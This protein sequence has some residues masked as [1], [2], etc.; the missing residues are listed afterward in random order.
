MLT[1]LPAS[2]YL[3]QQFNQTHCDRIIHLLFDITEYLMHFHEQ[4][5]LLP[6]SKQQT[7]KKILIIDDDK[8]VL[9]MLT[10]LI[11][12]AGYATLS[13]RDGEEG[14]KLFH[15]ENPDL[16]VTDLIMPNKEGL[17]V[18][19]EIRKSLHSPKIIAISGGGKLTPESYLPLAERLGADHV[20]EKPFL[21][22]N[23]IKIIC[24]LLGE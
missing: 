20:L 14:L 3:N 18:I 7:M 4:F 9:K 17:E 1:A 21:P 16:V 5:K 2:R 13:A 19:M 12:R 22:S 23:L 24:S 11:G 6:R 10:N 8:E 15:Q